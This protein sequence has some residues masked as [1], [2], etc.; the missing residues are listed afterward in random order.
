MANQQCILHPRSLTQEVLGQIE[1][2]NDLAEEIFGSTFY[3]HLGDNY[4]ATDFTEG[5]FSVGAVATILRIRPE[6]VGQLC[7]IG[8]LVGVTVSE[9]QFIVFESLRCLVHHISDGLR[10]YPFGAAVKPNAK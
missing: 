2:Y 8:M 6:T 5:L 3:P 7:S 9:T 10:I 1:S 4:P